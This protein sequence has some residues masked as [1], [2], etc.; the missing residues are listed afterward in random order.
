MRVQLD[1]SWAVYRRMARYALP[2]WHYLALSLLALALFSAADV[3]FVALMKPLLDG[4][5]VQK[6]LQTIRWIPF[7]IIGLF[8][9][10][11]STSFAPGYGMKWVSQQIVTS[12]RR[13]MLAP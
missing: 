11:G 10:R 3:G 1:S 4:S 2:H 13:E 12:L 7:A 8:L 6:D 9:L 5:F